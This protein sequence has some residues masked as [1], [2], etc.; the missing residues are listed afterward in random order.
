MKGLLP[1]IRNIIPISLSVCTLRD[2]LRSLY[3]RVSAQ[4][5]EPG[6]FIE[7]TRFPLVNTSPISWYRPD[8]GREPSTILHSWF[9][10]IPQTVETG[11]MDNNF[12]FPIFNFESAAATT[13]SAV[14]RASSSMG[15]CVMSHDEIL[16]FVFIWSVW[17]ITSEKQQSDFDQSGESRQRSNRV[18]ERW[19]CLTITS[20]D[21][22]PITFSFQNSISKSTEIYSFASI[23]TRSIVWLIDVAVIT[24]R[25]IV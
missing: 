12:F 6:S 15:V 22:I 3:L 14:D 19:H 16:T 1:N 23:W 24:S 25:E 7:P 21:W 4:R 11:N 9:A 13:S 18:C 20:R 2:D 5:L 17:W 10:T 8:L